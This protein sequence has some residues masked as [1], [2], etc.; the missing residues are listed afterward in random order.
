MERSESVLGFV[1]RKG[2]RHKRENE[3]LQGPGSRAKEQDRAIGSRLPR[4][5]DR[6]NCCL[7]YRWK[8]SI[9]DRQVEQCRQILNTTIP[10]ALRVL[11]VVKGLKDF[12]RGC[13]DAWLLF[14][15]TALPAVALV[16]QY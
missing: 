1:F 12:S 9:W 6:H 2:I 5:K 16:L 15:K 7:P 13:F 11:P 8:V 3:A 10:M 4:L 14:G